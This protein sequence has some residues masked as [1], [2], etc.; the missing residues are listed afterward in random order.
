MNIRIVCDFNGI[1]DHCYGDRPNVTK[2]NF[3]VKFVFNSDKT[4][5]SYRTFSSK[6]DF[7]NF[8]C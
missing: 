2:G 1:P 4:S 8:I 7:D 3:D 5:M 6:S